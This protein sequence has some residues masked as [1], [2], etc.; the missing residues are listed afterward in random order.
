MAGSIGLSTIEALSAIH[1]L[2]LMPASGQPEKLARIQK[3]MGL[4]SFIKQKILASAAHCLDDMNEPEDEVLYGTAG[5]L[6]CL[7]FLKHEMLRTVEPVIAN[8]PDAQPSWL[9]YSE[10][11][12]SIVSQVVIKLMNQTST[13]SDAQ[14]GEQIMTVVFPRHRRGGRPYVGGAHG[15]LGVLYLITQACLTDPAILASN[16][17]ALPVLKATFEDIL[18]LQTAEGG[19]PFQRNDSKDAKVVNHWCH[20]APGAIGPLLAGV[21]LLI[22]QQRMRDPQEAHTNADEQENERSLATRLYQAA[23][24]SA[25]LTWTN[26]LLLKGNSLCHGIS[27]NS[28]LLHSMARWHHK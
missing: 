5:Y 16:P 19:F 15:T 24:K 6:Q 21:Q 23:V 17:G 7:L 28:M 4:C 22:S 3:G 9:D 1:S 8:E 18:K 11:M 25:E 26:G 12:D 13:N 27:G 14:S 20:G 10:R 2:S